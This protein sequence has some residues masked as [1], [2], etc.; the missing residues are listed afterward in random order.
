MVPVRP[1][2]DFKIVD[3]AF[4][5]LLDEGPVHPIRR[6]CPSVARVREGGATDK[7]CTP[8]TGYFQPITL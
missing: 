5:Q 6:P 2:L 8:H 1:R 7:R 3:L 4:L